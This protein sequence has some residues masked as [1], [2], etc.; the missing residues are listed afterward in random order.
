MENEGRIFICYR[1][2][3]S[4]WQAFLHVKRQFTKGAKKGYRNDSVA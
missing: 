1:R 2:K 3:T 4:Q